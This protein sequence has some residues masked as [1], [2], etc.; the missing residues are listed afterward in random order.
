MFLLSMHTWIT[1]QN[2]PSFALNLILKKVGHTYHTQTIVGFGF[3]QNL[4]RLIFLMSCLR[5]EL[6]IENYIF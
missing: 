5:K 3:V 6:K 1:I 4:F 2:Y